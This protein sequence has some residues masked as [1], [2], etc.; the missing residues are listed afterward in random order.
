MPLELRPWQRANGVKHTEEAA[1]DL[2]QAL[3]L[4][5]IRLLHMQALSSGCHLTGEEAEPPVEGKAESAA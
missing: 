1:Q 3:G 2:V 5:R 4:E